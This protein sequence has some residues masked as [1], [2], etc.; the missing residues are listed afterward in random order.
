M[1]RDLSK[2]LKESKDLREFLKLSEDNHK[3]LIQDKDI[4]AYLLDYPV[5]GKTSDDTLSFIWQQAQKQFLKDILDDIDKDL[6]KLYNK[7][8]KSAGSK[9]QLVAY[10]ESL[11]TWLHSKYHTLKRKNGV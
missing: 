1:K 10:E 7:H 5:N 2:W 8:G 6:D 3:V 11:K 9:A 4:E